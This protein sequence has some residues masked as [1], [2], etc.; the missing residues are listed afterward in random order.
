MLNEPQEGFQF[1]RISRLV[2]MFWTQLLFEKSIFFSVR[3]PFLFKQFCKTH[4]C[5]QLIAKCPIL[6]TRF[7]LVLGLMRLLGKTEIT[8]RWSWYGKGTWV[9]STSELHDSLSNFSKSHFDSLLYFR[10]VYSVPF[11]VH[12]LSSW[13]QFRGDIVVVVV[14]P[15][16]NSQYYIFYTPP[17]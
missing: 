13:K 5:N 12:L 9:K 6:I 1:H 14:S 4:N 16:S 8:A 17:E 3:Q 10:G 7:L 15:P 2:S 11:F